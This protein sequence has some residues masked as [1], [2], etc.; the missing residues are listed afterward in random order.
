MLR[1]FTLSGISGSVV[2]SIFA[3]MFFEPLYGQENSII[4]TT[5]LFKKTTYYVDPGSYG[6]RREMNPPSYSHTLSESKI[7][8]LE[9]LDWLDFGGDYRC[10][11]EIRNNDLRRPTI[12]TDY[13]VLLRSRMY[14]GIKS[15]LDPFRFAVEFEDAHRV[16]SQFGKDTKDFNRAELIQAFAGL[17][18]ENLLPKDPLGNSRPVYLNF[19]RQTFEFLDRRLIGLNRWRNTT[20]NFVGF[21]GTVG[22]D[23]NDW[24][25]DL[26]ALR[27]I[28]RKVDQFDH[29]DTNRYFFGAIG[30]WRRHS[31]FVTVEPYY[32][33]LK[34]TPSASNNNLARM[35]HSPG[36]RLYGWLKD[37]LFNY[38]V[39]HTQ[40]FGTHGNLKMRAFMTTAELGVKLK[41]YLWK[42]RISLF[43]GFASGDKNPNDG[44]HNR[45]ERF[46]G[47]A[48]P[49]S[50]DDY[51]VPENVS[52]PKIRFEI[53]PA[54][55]IK[56]DFGYG[57]Y[58]LASSTDRFFNLFDGVNNRDVTGHSGKFLGHGFDARVQF[59]KV[60][61]IDAYVGY[62]HYRNG[63]FVLRRQHD[64]LGYSKSYS[65]FFYVEVS[66]SL[67]ELLAL[68]HPK[69]QS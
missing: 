20:N 37:G 28:E 53:Q 68:V 22:Q 61:F 67:V 11:S 1:N 6:T 47:F 4:D 48:R 7:S 36:I 46:Y 17:H 60:K 66:V 57:F 58:W 64:V 13:P 23:K 50:P 24:Q 55:K 45:F 18:F 16:N 41:N 21:R 15:I 51:I 56:A 29:R 62:A 43:Y 35:I 49:W 69:K 39:T 65:N 40:Q 54:K 5:L 52:A 12:T 30:H 63:D 25:V 32:L 44:Y 26:L 42:P 33:G 14:I 59:S 8:G 34:Q 19:G 31:E 3:M 10:R 27:P 9:K 2:C 38:D